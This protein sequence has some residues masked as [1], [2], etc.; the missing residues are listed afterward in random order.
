MAKQKKTVGIPFKKGDDARRNT[1]GANKGSRW[2]KSLLKELMTI[3]LS[4]EESE[5][6]F[7]KIKDKFPTIFKSTEER[8][9][10]LFMEL[11]QIA[12][13]SSTNEMTSQIA[14]NAIKDRVEGKPN[15]PIEIDPPEQGF[16]YSLLSD[17]AIQ[18]IAAQSLL[19]PKEDD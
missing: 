18:E 5:A 17:K 15:Q 7:Y 19:M 14:I 3:P 2:N 12:L 16:D 4:E 6:T 11:K 10:Q 9:L 1:T 8:N 13:M